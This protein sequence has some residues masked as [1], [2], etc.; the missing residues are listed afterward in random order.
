MLIPGYGKVCCLVNF[1]ILLF[2][3]NYFTFT[4]LY[5]LYLAVLCFALPLLTLSTLV[6]PLLFFNITSFDVMPIH[7][8]LLSSCS[9]SNIVLVLPFSCP[10]TH[11]TI[12]HEYVSNMYVGFVSCMTKHVDLDFYY[13]YYYRLLKD[14]EGKYTLAVEFTKVCPH[15]MTL[16]YTLVTPNVRDSLLNK[17]C[18][19]CR[20]ILP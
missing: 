17:L 1:C 2:F 15:N 10:H 16:F 5:L 9:E 11:P 14:T 20:I 6:V 8:N 4:L 7:F 18:P 13:R 3:T 12:V 19:F